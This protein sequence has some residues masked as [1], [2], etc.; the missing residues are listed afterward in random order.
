[1]LKR[2]RLTTLCP[3]LPDATFHP[4]YFVTRRGAARHVRAAKVLHGRMYTFRLTN[5]RTGEEENL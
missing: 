1:M 2:W 3:G 5:T 4:S